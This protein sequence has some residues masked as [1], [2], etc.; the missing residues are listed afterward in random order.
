M[1]RRCAE[2]RHR[3]RLVLARDGAG[4]HVV[5]SALGSQPTASGATVLARRRRLGLFVGRRQPRL[6][7]QPDAGAPCLEA[8][9]V[10]V[11]IDVG[12][13][14]PGPVQ[15]SASAQRG[16]AVDRA[17]FQSAS[18]IFRT[19]ERGDEDDGRRAR[20]RAQTADHTVNVHFRHHHA[21]RHPLRPR[22]ADRRR[23]RSAPRTGGADTVAAH[24][25][26]AG[27]GL[28]LRRVIDQKQGLLRRGRRALAWVLR[29]SPVLYPQRW[30]RPDARAGSVDDPTPPRCGRQQNTAPTRLC[31]A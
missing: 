19:V 2:P 13:R 27:Y 1:H 22:T 9:G 8:Q 11:G 20:T 10:E 30:H 15:A 6:P 7:L 4:S 31:G 17:Q 14:R 21:G 25:D 23:Q 26:F 16:D 5:V 3:R 28:I 18:F 24:Q 29:V 12:Q